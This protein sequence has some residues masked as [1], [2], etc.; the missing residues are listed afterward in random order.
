MSMQDLMEKLRER[1]KTVD[2]H[3]QEQKKEWLAA[4]DG[5]FG[6]IEGWIAPAVK[7]GLLR[8]S[9]SDMEI[10]E[11]DIGAYHAPILEIRDDRLL[12]R[13]MPVGARV[14]GVVV[15][16]GTRHIGLRGRID[17]VCGP[18]QIPIVRSSS[19]MWKALPLR[20]EPKDLNEETF[21]E[22]LSEVLLDE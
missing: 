17:L 19:G 13:L 8:V 20:G 11:E 14:A 2:E 16:G 12:V 22:I 7:E 9:R 1:P 4:L 21:S 15:S 6:D 3:R 10:I 18:I 5:L